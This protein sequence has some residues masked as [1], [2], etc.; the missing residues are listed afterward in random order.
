[1]SKHTPGPW[2]RH[3]HKG[4]WQII[5][6]EYGLAVGYIFRVDDADLVIAAPETAAERDRL[7]RECEQL[8]VQLAGCGVAALDGSAEQEATEDA[9]GWSPAYADVLKLRRDYDRLREANAELVDAL[10]RV[11]APVLDEDG[12]IDPDLA[13]AIAGRTLAGGHMTLKGSFIGY[14]EYARAAIAKARG[15]T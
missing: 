8:Q 13:S 1:M 5:A 7:R 6:D 14:V 11:I 9:Y 2:S 4:S 15:E 3:E 10:Q 12:L